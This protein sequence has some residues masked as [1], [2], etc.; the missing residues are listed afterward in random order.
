MGPRK[1]TIVDLRLAIF[2]GAD[3]QPMEGHDI[4]ELFA[5]VVFI[6]KS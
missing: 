1:L 3:Q 5:T 2:G 4:R 6:C